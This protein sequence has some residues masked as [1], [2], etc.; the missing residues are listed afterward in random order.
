MHSAKV[1][2][3]S[4]LGKPGSDEGVELGVHDTGHQDLI[5]LRMSHADMSAFP[6]AC[7]SKSNARQTSGALPGPLLVGI[8]GARSGIV[9]GM[10]TGRAECDYSGFNP[11]D[12]VSV[13]EESYEKAAACGE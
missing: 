9:M 1:H 5:S 3:S 12:V 6:V 7:G 13:P 4:Y 8:E 10:R 2:Q 11:F